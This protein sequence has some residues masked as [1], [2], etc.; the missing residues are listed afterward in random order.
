MAK[1]AR[2]AKTLYAREAILEYLDD[3]E[4]WY[5][6]EKVLDDIRS[7]REETV[8]LEEVMREYGLLED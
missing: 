4:D 3:L 2:R 8:P 5:R 7:G 1:A 6:A